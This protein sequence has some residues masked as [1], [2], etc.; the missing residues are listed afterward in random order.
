MKFATAY[1]NVISSSP[2]GSRYRQLYR[3]SVDEDGSQK[4]VEAGKEDVYDSIQKA[5]FGN[6]LSD[7]IRRSSLGDL[8]AIPEPIDSYGDISEMPND[9]LSAHRFLSEAKLKYDALP[10]N[11]K[12]EFNNSFEN[13]LAKV[14][15]GSIISVLNSYTS[16][17]DE[18]KKVISPED[19]NAE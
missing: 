8:D 16:K 19:H 9:L 15:D 7:L 18:V 4:L 3:R 11:L 14:G 10:A 2:T 13:F 17:V 1:E 12:S 6:L 5:A